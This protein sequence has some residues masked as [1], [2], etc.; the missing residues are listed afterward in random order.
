MRENN[1]GKNLKALRNVK[2][3]TLEQA[4]DLFGIKQKQIS[5]YE[6]GK[7][8]PKASELKLFSELYGV[9]LDD[10]LSAEITLRYE[11]KQIAKVR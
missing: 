1:L 4:G 5:F 8:E 3:L 10:L 9:T 6:T 11:I 7:R 2:M